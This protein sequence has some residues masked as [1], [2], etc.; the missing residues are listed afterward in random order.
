MPSASL[1]DME[2]KTSSSH[3]MLKRIVAP[4]AVW[5]VTKVLETPKVRKTMV[6]LYKMELSIAIKISLGHLR[7][8]H[9]HT[10]VQLFTVF[11]NY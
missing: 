4:L 3:D 6:I 9:C 7:E 2:V 10:K 5:A 11:L 1:E 8:N